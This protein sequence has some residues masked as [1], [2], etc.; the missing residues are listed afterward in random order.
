V[1][2]EKEIPKGLSTNISSSTPVNNTGEVISFRASLEDTIAP[3]ENIYENVP[4]LIQLNSEQNFHYNT[5]VTKKNDK[6]QG[7]KPY[8]YINITDDNDPELQKQ[9]LSQLF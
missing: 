2:I 5:P 9:Y 1:V 8:L 4:I 6:Q 3:P 7:N